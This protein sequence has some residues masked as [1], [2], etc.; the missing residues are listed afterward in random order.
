MIRMCISS[1]GSEHQGRMDSLEQRLEVSLETLSGVG[2]SGKHR[3]G[4]RNVCL[5]CEFRAVEHRGLVMEQSEDA[6]VRIAEKELL[7]AGNTQ[8]GSSRARFLH[9]LLREISH[10]LA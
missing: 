4:I 2:V 9:T 8:E 5:A 1:A 10:L 6:A 7:R 3:I